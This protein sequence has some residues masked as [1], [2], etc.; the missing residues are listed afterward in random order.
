MKSA[1]YTVMGGRAGIGMGWTLTRRWAVRPE[2]DRTGK[3]DKN[4]LTRGT[5]LTRGS[6]SATF[7]W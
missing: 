7:R 3:L 4:I 6:I 1:S 2:F 5:R